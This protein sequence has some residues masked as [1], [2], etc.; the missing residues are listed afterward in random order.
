MSTDQDDNH[1]RV[2]NFDVSSDEES[3]DTDVKITCRRKLFKEK[4]DFL[5]AN[6]DDE[7]AK[8]NFTYEEI[9]NII[10]D[11]FLSNYYDKKN[12][13]ALL[14]GI[15]EI[16]QW[17]K[18]FAYIK[19][20]NMPRIPTYDFRA[21]HIQVGRFPSVVNPTAINTLIHDNFPVVYDILAMAKGKMS[22]CGGAL[23]EILTYEERNENPNDFDIFFHC[24]GVKEADELLMKSLE[25]IESKSEDCYYTISLGVLTA[26]ADDCKIQ[27]IR[28]IYKTKDQILL[29]FDLSACRH[30]WNPHDGYFA[31]VCGAISFSMRAFPLDL[32]QRSLSH[33]H[34]LQ[35]YNNKEFTILLPGL[36]LDWTGTLKT[37]DGTI[38]R[39]L[40]NDEF[41]FRSETTKWNSDYDNNNSFFNW[42]L[43]A[44]DKDQNVSFF[45]ETFEDVMDLSN[46]I[47]SSSIISGSMDDVPSNMKYLKPS[48]ARKYLG[49]TYKDFAT[50]FYVNEDVEEGDRIWKER[51]IFYIERGTEIALNIKK[52]GWKT[53][54]PGSQ[55]FGKIHPIIADPRE[56]YGRGY[57]PVIVGI[58]DDRFVALYECRKVDYLQPIPG[59]IFKLLCQYWFEAE[60]RDARARLFSLCL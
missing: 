40:K 6:L 24:D 19:Y 30:G 8:K 57:E 9:S 28:R 38:S 43:I 53:E 41:N 15:D 59:E 27:F 2:R 52:N 25:I 58:S 31:T 44:N 29:G 60:V 17:T 39:Y 37:P 11:V 5:P 18:Y 56:W 45:A 50:A 20:E 36:P 49:D 3:V 13:N 46:F 23:I 1:K 22:L 54:N 35:K 42:W 14:V 16:N 7:N 10:N 21:Y 33:G 51:S 12:G 32:T 26:H 4:K 48:T 47:I 55:S 34:R